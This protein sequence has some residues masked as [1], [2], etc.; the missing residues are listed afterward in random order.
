MKG[1]RQKAISAKLDYDVLQAMEAER[2]VT[3]MTRNRMLNVSV[4]VYCDLQDTIRRIRYS[5]SKD[6]KEEY[7]RDFLRMH[8][9][10][11]F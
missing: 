6:M 9:G 4:M 11:A 8:Y 2:D 1:I 10:L 5:T 3:G 7:L